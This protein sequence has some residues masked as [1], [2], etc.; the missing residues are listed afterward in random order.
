MTVH[1]QDSS[2][3]FIFIQQNSTNILTVSNLY[4]YCPLNITNG[5]KITYTDHDIFR[6]LVIR[7]LC[8]IGTLGRNSS[9]FRPKIADHVI[10][11]G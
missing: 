7:G 2:S 9:N 5:L 6:F 3:T 1:L 8:G 4:R 11:G 10:F